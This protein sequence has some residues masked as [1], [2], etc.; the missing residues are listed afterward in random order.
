MTFI[1]QQKQA[2][3]IVEILIEKMM[4]WVREVRR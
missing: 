1:T 3:G 4:R 2:V